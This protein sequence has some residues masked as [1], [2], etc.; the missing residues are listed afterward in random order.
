MYSPEMA[1]QIQSKQEQAAQAR[2]QAVMAEREK[3]R[4]RRL[5]FQGKYE[6][7]LSKAFGAE[8]YEDALEI[9]QQ[10][11]APYADILD[12]EAIMRDRFTPAAFEAGRGVGPSKEDEQKQVNALRSSIEKTEKDYR[13]LE[14]AFSRMDKASKRDTAAS[15]MSLI[16]NFMKLN[17]P[18]STVR[19]GEFATAQNAAGVP[20][21][22]RN[23]WNNALAGTR[24]SPKQRDDFMATAKSLFIG[25][26]E[27]TNKQIK[28]I[29]DQGIQD[30]IDGERILGKM[31]FDE[32]QENFTLTPQNEGEVRTTASGF[33]YTVE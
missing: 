16:F 8:N 31:R 19:E 22:V 24:L 32:L 18:G 6:E 13:L 29:L 25:Q 10:T 14:N 33:E 12:V 23:A 2:Q 21:R 20:E 27:A 1:S 17:D 28:R 9:M 5:D 7:G 4:Q 3:R 26:K 11:V 30:R 15:D